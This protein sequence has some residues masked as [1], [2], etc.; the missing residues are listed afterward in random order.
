[1]SCCKV[2]AHKKTVILK[3]VIWP[4]VV[5]HAFTLPPAYCVNSDDISVCD[6]MN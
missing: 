6:E 4:Y 2:A 3:T 1:M 5:V